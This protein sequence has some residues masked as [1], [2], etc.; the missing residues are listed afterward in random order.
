[1]TNIVAN[2]DH[3]VELLHEKIRLLGQ[4]KRVLL[5]ADLL[6]LPPKEVKGKVGTHVSGTHHGK[7]P[8]GSAEF[9]IKVDGVPKATFPL[10]QVPLDLWPDDM[11]QSYEMNEKR[12]AR[13]VR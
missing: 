6:G 3:M 13:H 4:L 10:L 12:K 2:I 1:M 9:V 7:T 8:W 11:R 5:I